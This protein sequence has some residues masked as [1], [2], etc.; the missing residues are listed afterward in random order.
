MLHGCG[1]DD[2]CGYVSTSKRRMSN[3]HVQNFKD[4]RTQGHSLHIFL[5]Q[6]NGASYSKNESL[7]GFLNS[8]C[9]MKQV[10]ICP[11]DTGPSHI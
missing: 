8:V 10:Q 5:F 2:G 1:S 6:A 3:S 9:P 4:T 7:A 11:M